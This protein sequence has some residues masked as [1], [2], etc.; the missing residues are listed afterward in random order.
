LKPG[1]IFKGNGLKPVAF[2][3]WVNRVQ[4]APPRLG[5]AVVVDQDLHVL[6]D[7]AQPLDDVSDVL[8]ALDV[9][10]QVDQFEKANFE[11]DFSLRRLKG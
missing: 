5:A 6:G 11:T 8:R 9:A 2:K 7:G 4:L 10:A 3:L 1:L